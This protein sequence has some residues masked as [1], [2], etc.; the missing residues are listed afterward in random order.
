MKRR[1]HELAPK[2]VAPVEPNA[3]ERGLAAQN[4]GAVSHLGPG[5]RDALA[6]LLA[7]YREEVLSAY[8]AVQASVRRV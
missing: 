8:K 6:Q 5:S 1:G 7:E 3:R 2:E 4:I